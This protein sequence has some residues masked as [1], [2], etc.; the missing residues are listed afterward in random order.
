MFSVHTVP[1]EMNNQGMFLFSFWA[2]ARCGFVQRDNCC[3]NVLSSTSLRRSGHWCLISRESRPWNFKIQSPWPHNPCTFTCARN[4]DL[5][6][7][8]IMSWWKGLCM[9][10]RTKCKRLARYDSHALAL[11][12]R[13]LV[14]WPARPATLQLGHIQD[15]GQHITPLCSLFC[16]PC[17][18]NEAIIFRG[19]CC[20]DDRIAT[21]P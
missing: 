8:S 4:L 5:R 1:A 19:P 14:S 15:S 18:M 9:C 11:R 13:L 20:F 21:D 3:G 17:K 2:R 10:L 12:N 7:C 16:L 6:I